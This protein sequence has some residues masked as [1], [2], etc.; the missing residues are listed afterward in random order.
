LLFY[1]PPTEGGYGSRGGRGGRSRGG[2]HSREYE[3][4]YGNEAMP[5]IPHFTRSTAKKEEVKVK[6][7][8]NP[9]A[10]VTKDNP[11]G[12]LKPRDE[13]EY[14]KHKAV[15]APTQEEEPKPL[16]PAQ[17]PIQAP[18]PQPEKRYVEYQESY[19]QESYAE[20]EE[21]EPEEGYQGGYRG[22]YPGPRRSSRFG[23]R[24]GR[25]GSRRP[26]YERGY[27]GGGY[28]PYHDVPAE[29]SKF[30]AAKP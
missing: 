14:E 5:E 30:I 28:A 7:D 6:T 11:F 20:V 1:D 13:S 15:R 8:I 9:V 26:Y 12:G 16:P 24:G 29:C 17:A 4:G 22:R 25:Y 2:Y 19:K 23:R 27:Y 3:G 18:A 21:A 10:A